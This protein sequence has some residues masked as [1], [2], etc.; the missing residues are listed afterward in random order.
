MYVQQTYE[1]IRLIQQNGKYHVVMDCVE[2]EL[3]CNY[4]RRECVIDKRFS[5][6]IALLLAKELSYLEKSE[7]KELYPFFTPMHIVV[8]KD[9]TIAFLKFNEKY[10]QHIEDKVSLF[11]RPDG[12]EDYIYSYGKTI[13]FLLSNI[14]SVP[15]L[16]WAEERKFKTIISKCLN[17]K[18]NKRY[19]NSQDI[20]NQLTPQKK[21]NL[22]FVLPVLLF[23]ILA[24]SIY[25]R[26]RTDD[27]AI[28][29]IEPQ[30]NSY[31]ILREFLDGERIQSNEEIEKTIRSY[32]EA[33]GDEISVAQLDFLF[34]LYCELN[35]NYGKKEALNVANKLFETL[36]DYREI[37]AN[38]YIEQNNYDDAIREFEILIKESPTVERYASLANLLELSGRQREAMILCEE[39]SRFDSEGS[40]LQLQYVRLLLMDTEYS[41]NDK[42]TKLDEFLSMYPI[43]KELK[44]FQEI[45]EQTN[46]KEVND[47]SK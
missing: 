13:Q 19:Q 26:M 10:N 14:K 12:V 25:I 11:L 36:A 33:L 22:L 7:G 23:S 18:S 2:G 21:K 3:L 39:G 46:F 8:K 24:M 5:L 6:E 41:S 34:Q 43:V 40:E 9:G 45:K 17:Y 15:K 31:Q 16:S 44:R 20:V 32:R 4:L 27:T 28:K 1:V 35:N 29:E 37:L 42:K 47:E 30:K 38:I